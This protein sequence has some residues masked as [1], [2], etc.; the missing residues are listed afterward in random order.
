MRLLPS[1]QRACERGRSDGGV[2]GAHGSRGRGCARRDDG[3]VRRA[4]GRAWRAAS[5]AWRGCA[6]RDGGGVDQGVKRGGLPAV[7]GAASRSGAGRGD[8][9][10]RERRRRCCGEVARHVDGDRGDGAAFG[11]AAAVSAEAKWRG[12]RGRAVG[13]VASVGAPYGARGCSPVDMLGPRRAWARAVELGLACVAGAS[14][15]RMAWARVVELSPACVGA[16]GGARSCMRGRERW[17]SVLHVSRARAVELGLAC[18]GASGGA[19]SCMRGHE[20][21]SS[22]LHVSRGEQRRRE[23]WSSV[24]HAW[25]RAVELGSTRGALS[26]ARR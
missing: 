22:V 12:A 9:G 17:S 5:A 2:C 24:L 26:R 13:D 6:R 20:R 8:D 4:R 11:A 21:W 23:R 16:S 19:R 3:S 18:V 10:S 15:A 7:Q 1:S 14:G 25:V